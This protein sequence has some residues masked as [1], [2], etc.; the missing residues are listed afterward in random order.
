M[1]KGIMTSQDQQPDFD[2]DVEQRLRDD[3]SG[4]YRAELRTRLKEMHNACVAAGRQ[5]QDRE[6]YRRLE[7][8]IAAVGAAATALDL[9]PRAG[10]ARQ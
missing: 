10:A 4:Q 6:T 2:F 8:A 7:A 3:T 5:L 1:K 9:M